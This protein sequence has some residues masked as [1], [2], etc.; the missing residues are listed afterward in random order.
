MTE[1]SQIL[2]TLH[3]MQ[4]QFEELKKAV[5]LRRPPLTRREFA[6]ATG[7]SY[8]T[9]CRKVWAKE[10]REVDGRIPAKYL[11]NYLS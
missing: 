1:S 6:D 9:I 5:L 11:D 8:Q 7:L 10:I 2:N 4:R 3:V